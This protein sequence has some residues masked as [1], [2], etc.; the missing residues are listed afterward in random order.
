M[1][2][3]LQ[4]R[5]RLI[6]IIK[7]YI[8]E[9]RREEKRREAIKKYYNSIHPTHQKF[10]R[11]IKELGILTLEQLQECVFV[12]KIVNNG[13][14]DRKNKNEKDNDVMSKNIYKHNLGTIIGKIKEEEEGTQ[15]C[16]C[17]THITNLYILYHPTLH[18][19]LTIGSSC[20]E[21]FIPDLKV[22]ID[23][24]I[25]EYN[26]CNKCNKPRKV[27]N[28]CK[29]C[30]NKTLC[31]E[32]KK[33]IR[34]EKGKCYSCLYKYECYFCPNKLKKENDICVICNG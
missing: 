24:E 16:Y 26:K 28:L 10:R 31:K 29:V 32:C 9:C 25:V 34:I 15:Y 8:I 3:N 22:E 7:K 2:R 5:N 14:E 4:L 1:I 6:T 30:Y 12:A 23:A 33:N 13:K 27:G 20:I 18:I 21:T 19:F 11:N 17:E